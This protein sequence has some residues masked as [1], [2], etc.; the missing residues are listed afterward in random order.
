MTPR[1]MKKMVWEREGPDS[2]PAVRRGPPRCSAHGHGIFRKNESSVSVLFA[3]ACS[4]VGRPAPD[5]KA[6]AHLPPIFSSHHVHVPLSW[7]IDWLQRF[8]QPVPSMPRPAP[9]G[10]GCGVQVF[11]LS[12]IHKSNKCLTPGTVLVTGTKPLT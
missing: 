3:P 10:A 1:K 11:F 7:G 4:P 9:T 8:L 2:T 12:S 6:H 5:P